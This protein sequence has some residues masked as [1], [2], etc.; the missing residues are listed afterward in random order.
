M[1]FGSPEGCA[2]ALRE[3]DLYRS[4]S[5]VWEIDVGAQHVGVEMGVYG[6]ADSTGAGGAADAPMRDEEAVAVGL[7]CPIQVGR[8]FV[9]V[10]HEP[11][12]EMDGAVRGDVGVGLSPDQVLQGR[13][14]EPSGARGGF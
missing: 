7:G 11:C 1:K 5:P 12:Q 9:E 8:Q 14:V 6:L 3:G 2:I 4:L 13:G 10:F